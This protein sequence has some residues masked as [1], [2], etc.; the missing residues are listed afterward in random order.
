MGRH[1]QADFILTS[2]VV[3]NKQW[4]LDNVHPN[5][6]AGGGVGYVQSQHGAAFAAFDAARAGQLGGEATPPMTR[7]SQ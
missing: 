3:R 2:D 1:H 6:Q 5:L 4:V 7:A